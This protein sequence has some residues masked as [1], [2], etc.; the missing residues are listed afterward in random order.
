MVR[1]QAFSII[2]ASHGSV[3][4]SPI[5]NLKITVIVI[6]MGGGK[7]FQRNSKIKQGFGSGLVVLVRPGSV[8]GLEMNLD[9]EPVFKIWSDP[10]PVFRYG[11]IRNR[12]SNMVGSGFQN[13]VG[14][15]FTMVGSSFQNIIG[16]GSGSRYGRIRIHEVYILCCK[17]LKS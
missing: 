1:T 3:S 14:S 8:F 5:K 6:Y 9:P 16:S 4:L 2:F 11:R 13:M 17:K 10:D 12:F 15:C 7:A